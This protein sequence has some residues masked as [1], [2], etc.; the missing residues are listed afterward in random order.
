M[1]NERSLKDR[2]VAYASN[3]G[4]KQPVETIKKF[5][6]EVDEFALSIAL[7]LNKSPSIS[8]DSFNK[9]SK[10]NLPIYLLYI[11]KKYQSVCDTGISIT[12]Y[13][14]LI[15]ETDYS[16]ERKL[17]QIVVIWKRKDSMFQIISYCSK[18]ITENNFNEKSYFLWNID[19]TD[20]DTYTNSWKE[21]SLVSLDKINLLTLNEAVDA[22][23]N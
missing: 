7:K 4:G 20:Q 6:F 12:N 5:L 13:N 11:I 17:G 22:L 18:K 8:E 2:L 1:E 16:K 3:Y 23:Q 19:C 10:F 15:K 21:Y 14:N 9:F